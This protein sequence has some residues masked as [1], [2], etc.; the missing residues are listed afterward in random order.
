M[1]ALEKENRNNCYFLGVFSKEKK[2]NQNAII[3]ITN[4]KGKIARKEGM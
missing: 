4:P 2:N 3:S 1:T